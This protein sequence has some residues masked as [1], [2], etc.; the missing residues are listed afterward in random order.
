[1]QGN[2]ILT[3]HPYLLGRRVYIALSDLGYIPQVD[4]FCSIAYGDQHF[5]DILDGIEIPSGFQYDPFIFNIDFPTR[6]QNI[7]GGNTALKFTGG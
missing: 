1:M 6:A 3:I 2:G 7:C 4:L 5:L